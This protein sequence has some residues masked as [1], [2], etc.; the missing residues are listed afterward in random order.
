[1][2]KIPVF[3]LKKEPIT[4]N[5]NPCVCKSSALAAFQQDGLSRVFRASHASCEFHNH[6]R[7]FECFEPSSCYVRYSQLRSRPSLLWIRRTDKLSRS[8]LSSLCFFQSPVDMIAFGGRS[9]QPPAAAAEISE[10]IRQHSAATVATAH[11]ASLCHVDNICNISD[12]QAVIE[13]VIPTRVVSN[14]D[15]F[16][17]CC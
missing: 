5:T 4:K 9:T 13:A 12:W 17:H 1:M 15:G 7:Y 16:S 8:G 2:I 14:D 6:T 3:K 10:C 11:L